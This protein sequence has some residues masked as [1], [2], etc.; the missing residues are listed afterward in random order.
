MQ[1]QTTA[2][3]RPQVGAGLADPPNFPAPAVVTQSVRTQSQ[4]PL[5]H[6]LLAAA[7][8]SLPAGAYM[9]GEEAD[10]GRMLLFSPVFLGAGSAFWFL[11]AS[12]LPLVPSLLC[13]LVSAAAVFLTGPSRPALRASLMA[14]A[15]FAGGMLSAQ[16]E[17]WRASTVILDSSV[18]TTV[19][20]RV[21][22]REGDGRGRWRY[23]L[24][25]TG[26]EAP[27]LK[28]PPR[29]ITAIVRGADA[30][31]E[32]GDIITGKARLTPPAG[33][34]LPALNDF[35][36]GAYFDGI[37]ANGFFYGAP[38]KLDLEAGPQ[39]AS[40]TS[41]ALLEWLYRLRSSIGDRIRSILPGDTGAFAAA[42]VTDER[43]AISKTTTEALR[44]SGLAHIVAISG[45]NMAL[46]AGIF[47]V[48]FRM[49]LCLFPGV[50]Q[51]YPTKKIAAAGA[52]MAVTA[53]YLIS[54]FGVSAERA[55]IMMTI[56]LIAVFFDR[57]SISLRN[58]VLSAL[59]IIAISPSEVLGP[60]FQMSFAATLALVSGYQLWKD[61]RVRENAFLKLPIIRPVVVVAGFFGGV[62]LTSLI[63][64]FSTALFSIEHFHRL[65]AYGLPANLAT[66]P[67]ISFI[68]MPA[69][70]LAMLLMPFGLDAPLW[71]VV[72]F[73]LDLVIAVAKTVSG[74][75]GDIGIGRLPAWYFAVAVA[76]FLLLTLLRTRLRHVGTS[77]IA[78]STLTVLLLPAPRPPDL[79]ISEDG[80]LVAVVAAE[81]IASNREN[82][83]DFI[84]DQWQRALVLPT[85]VPPKMLDGPAIPPEGE[86]RRVRLSRDQQNE[87]SAAMR[88]AAAGGEANRFSCVKKA[89]CTS[90]LGNGHIVTV[91][92]NAAYLGPACDTADI[93]VT[94]VRLRFNSCRS[95]GTLFTGETLRRTGSVE[96]RFADAGLQVATAFEALSRPWMRHRAYD[97]RKDSFTE[98]GPAAVSDNGE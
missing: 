42:L 88:A 58:V 10:Y 45:L 90:R 47:F 46:S 95:G 8:Q 85:H 57:P 64:G 65:T 77:I 41:D 1:E 66:M 15:L 34:A 3:L 44:Q 53:Y 74:W 32:I 84:F 50:A 78:V 30:P 35:S 68:V 70:L 71:T 75:G 38:E 86:D 51:A 33:P 26:T 17:S 20:G 52:L 83:P 36:F 2:E 89:W 59:I 22:R 82:P 93:V 92:D 94:S 87:A 16:F 27:E 39:A 25:V 43:R 28:R 40:S 11:A 81:A 80:G 9:L 37:G 18:T 31:F 23:I 19:T 54:G 12:D 79:V 96:L 6:R 4:T 72:G 61:R 56:M 63:G 49:L 21:E 67:I 24:A 7:R 73:G 60:S 14:L 5:R 13:L 98:S 69:G 62:F 91:I 76:G 55:F 48:G 97:W 29:R